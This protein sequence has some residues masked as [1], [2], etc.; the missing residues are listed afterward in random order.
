MPQAYQQNGLSSLA[1]DPRAL[2]GSACALCRPLILLCLIILASLIFDVS[3]F[4]AGIA[5][6][7]DDQGMYLMHAENIR[8]SK[9][10]A[11][12]YYVYN[13]DVSLVGPRLYPPVWPLLLA[14]PLTFNDGN[15]EAVKYTMLFW[16][17]GLLVLVYFLARS[18]MS[19]LMALL[20]VA[21]LALSPW[22]WHYKENL[23]SEF[24]FMFLMLSALLVVEKMDSRERS[25]RAY[26]WWGLAAG[27]LIALT[28]GTRLAGLVF[29]P[30][31]VLYDLIRYR[32]LRLVTLWIWVVGLVAFSLLLLFYGN[33]FTAYGNMLA[34]PFP[35]APGTN[36][37][38]PSS[39]IVDRIL[40][41]PQHFAEFFISLT[42]LWS[43]GP[44]NPFV[45]T[46][47]VFILG[48]IMIG[49][50][51]T[52]LG[53]YSLADAFAL[54]Y[55]ALILILP[56]RA[57]AR[58]VMPLMPLAAIYAVFAFT[59]NPVQSFDRFRRI[60]L[61]GLCTFFTLS[62]VI[63]QR[64]L[65]HRD[66][67]NGPTSPDAQAMIRE[68]QA[69]VGEGERISFRKARLLAAFSNR[70]VVRLGADQTPAD[71]VRDIERFNIRLVIIDDDPKERLAEA[72]TACPGFFQRVGVFGP[73]RLY[74]IDSSVSC[75]PRR[76]SPEL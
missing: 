24:P 76:I 40:D 58:L 27:G 50:A 66:F 32:R 73:Y 3:T 43:I 30:A 59:G 20:P 60:G 35:G 31:L 71:Y 28:C 7:N 23:L 56:F 46:M 45:L 62:A 67:T 18:R 44:S 17:A 15:I 11:Q 48:S 14:L 9:P 52:L 29:F 69:R 5:W 25:R 1:S 61:I 49:Y 6:S 68:I 16:K 55:F 36:S 39:D 65:P 75:P 10:Y 72:V 34:N 63:S 64:H 37:V 33:V 47:G 26:V 38:P 57:D 51:C 4:R 21:G 22:L 13:P 53:R 19:A 74:Q 2:E 54:G 41:I 12:T 8:A 42:A 70:P